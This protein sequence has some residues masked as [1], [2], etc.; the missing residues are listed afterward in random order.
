MDRFVAVLWKGH[1]KTGSF[2]FST[3]KKVEVWYKFKWKFRSVIVE[4]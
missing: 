3:P 1:F 4:K 2:H